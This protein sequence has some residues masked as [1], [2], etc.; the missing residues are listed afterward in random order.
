MQ[1]GRV[2]KCGVCLW[3][4]VAITFRS[5]VVSTSGVETTILNSGGRRMSGNIGSGTGRFGVVKNMV[6][7]IVILMVAH[8]F[9]EKPCISGLDVVFQTNPFV[10]GHVTVDPSVT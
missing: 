5:K 6:D 1:V 3:N 7:V 8:T 10:S 2:R 9:P 4:R